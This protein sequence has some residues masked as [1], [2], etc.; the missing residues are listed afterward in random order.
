MVTAGHPRVLLLL[1]LLVAAVTC[2]CKSLESGLTDR[3][4]GSV[5]VF[6]HA[7]LTDRAFL[8]DWRDLK[9]DKCIIQQQLYNGTAVDSRLCYGSTPTADDQQW[10]LAQRA[11]GMS[12]GCARHHVSYCMWFCF[13]AAARL[14]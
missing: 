2:G 4:I 11:G 14:E 8:Y 12:I 1:L 5:T 3:L 9:N 10:L 13:A 6:L 7:L